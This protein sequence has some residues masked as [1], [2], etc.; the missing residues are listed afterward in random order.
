[1]YFKYLIVFNWWLSKIINQSRPNMDL[2]E[3]KVTHFN[4]RGWYA[5]YMYRAYTNWRP[6]WDFFISAQW[7]KVRERLCSLMKSNV[8]CRMSFITSFIWR[9]SWIHCL[10]VLSRFSDPVCYCVGLQ[11]LSVGSSCTPALLL[12]VCESGCESLKF[13]EDVSSL[14]MVFA[15]NFC[16]TLSQHHHTKAHIALYSN[17]CFISRDHTLWSNTLISCVATIRGYPITRV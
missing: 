16:I 4:N 7:S 14:S 11:Q 5:L 1:M 8:A 2:V 15:N 10:V 12:W 17:L 9:R 3:I 13:F 6:S